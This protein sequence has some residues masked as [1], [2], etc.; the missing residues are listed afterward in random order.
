M[1]K[2][3]SGLMVL[4][5]LAVATSTAFACEEGDRKCGPDNKILECKCPMYYNKN[6]C[7][8]AWTG[9]NCGSRSEIDSSIISTVR[10]EWG[11][12]SHQLNEEP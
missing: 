9:Y 7:R 5:G 12:E 3:L 10:L 1:N 2:I 4:A 11:M 8:W 6:Q